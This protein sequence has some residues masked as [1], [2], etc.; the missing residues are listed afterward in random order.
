MEADML[1]IKKI[2][3]DA[4]EVRGALLRKG[5]DPSALDEVIELDGNRRNLLSEVEAQKNRRNTV[6]K[7]IGTLKKN[8]EDTS[9]IQAEMRKLGEDIAELDKQAADTDEKLETVLLSIPNTPHSSCPEGADE[10]GNMV[11]R[12]HGKPRDFNFEPKTHIELGESLGILDLARA[13][14][15]TA[16]GFPLYMGQGARLQ[17]A[18]IQFMLDMH[19]NDHGYTEVSPPFLCNSAAM[20]GT[21]QLPKMADDMYHIAADDLYLVPTAEVPVTNIYREEILEQ[22]LPISLTACTPCWRREAGAAGKETRGIIRVHQFDKVEMVKFVEPTTS[23]DELE[24]LV[25][26]AEDVL[27]KLGLHYRVQELCAGDL[28]FAAAKC[29]DIDLWAPGQ[30]D[31]LEVSSCSNFE[32]FQARRAKIRYRNDA[33]KTKFVHTLNGSGVALPRLMVAILENCQEADGSISLPE[34]IVPYMD[35]ISKIG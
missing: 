4:Q 20:T 10:S 1:D 30:D 29:Y 16:P 3:D 2:R 11:V 32:D 12:E 22:P 26:N 19:V 15:M 17:R 34:A 35:G 8:G 18:L 24:V 28:S 9:A 5:V 31:W 25:T 6:S 7:E 33:G 14:R 27:Q 21:G 13:T 23:Y